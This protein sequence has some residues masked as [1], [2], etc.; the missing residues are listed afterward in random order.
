LYEEESVILD[1]MKEHRVTRS[2]FNAIAA[3]WDNG[4]IDTY[5]TL[6]DLLSQLQLEKTHAVLD[7]GCGT[8]VL[9]PLLRQLTLGRTKLFA[10]DFAH[11]MTLEAAR[12]SHRS[13][14]ILCGCAQ[15]LPFSDDTFDRIIAFHVFPHI[16]HKVQALQECRRV[17]RPGGKLGIIHLHSSHEINSIHAE[18]GGTIKHHTLPP[19]ARMNSLLRGLRYAVETSIDQ[20]GRYFI[21]AKKVQ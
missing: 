11:R 16:H 9:F 1:I 20:P 2:Y 19:G 17:M 7:L 14:R 21:V 10:V 13:F 5:G 8:G 18:I 4:E 15:H 3:E 6:K 12:K